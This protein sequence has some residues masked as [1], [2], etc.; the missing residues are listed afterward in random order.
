MGALNSLR[1]Y[2]TDVSTQQYLWLPT[3]TGVQRLLD[4]VILASWPTPDFKNNP[5]VRLKFQLGCPYPYALDD[6]PQTT[7]SITPGEGITLTNGG[8][9]PGLPIMFL[10]GPSDYISVTNLQ[11]G[12]THHLQL[13][14]ARRPVG[15]FGAYAP[16]RLPRRVSASRR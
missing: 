13:D 15:A 6:D 8:N 5:E 3:G 4:G 7:D 16:V 2:P 10:P 11:N 12:L 9:S 1:T 14:A